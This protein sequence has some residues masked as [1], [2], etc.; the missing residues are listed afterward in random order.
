MRRFEDVRRRCVEIANKWFDER[1]DLI[2]N[3]QTDQKQVP[4]LRADQC[5]FTM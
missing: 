4:C 5:V 1:E 2:K 3:S